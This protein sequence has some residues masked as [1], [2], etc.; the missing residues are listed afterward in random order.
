MSAADHGAQE[1]RRAQSPKFSQEIESQKVSRIL[2][3]KKKGGDAGSGG[4]KAKTTTKKSNANGGKTAKAAPNQKN[5]R[6]IGRSGIKKEG[7]QKG[8][9]K[10]RGLSPEERR[11]E[12]ARRKKNAKDKIAKDEILY[13]LA[14]QNDGHWKSS[15]NSRLNESSGQRHQPGGPSFFAPESLS[16]QG[17]PS[18]ANMSSCYPPLSPR[19]QKKI[20]MATVELWVLSE[21]IQGIGDDVKA[22]SEQFTAAHCKASD[23]LAGIHER[24]VQ[25]FDEM[26]KLGKAPPPLPSKMARDEDASIPTSTAIN[27]IKTLT[28]ARRP[29]SP[30]PH[31]R[32]CGSDNNNHSNDSSGNNNSLITGDVDDALS[33]LLRDFQLMPTIEEE[34]KEKEEEKKEEEEEKRNDEAPDADGLS[35]WWPLSEADAGRVVGIDPWEEE[36]KQ[37]EKMDES[38]FF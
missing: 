26:S 22:A 1:D 36:E 13:R 21:R 17:S 31:H 18:D 16:Q 30:Y 28:K 20:E 7:R 8:C 23:E 9:G 24:Q 12:A 35:L 34:E 3:K 29:D 2:V 15:K 10:A 11:K 19:D 32:N 38:R 6:P 14:N 25:I 33:N 27:G 37:E 5:G 4:K